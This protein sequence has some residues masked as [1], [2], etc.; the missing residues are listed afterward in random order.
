MHSLDEEYC[1]IL[2]EYYRVK[3]RRK[4]SPHMSWSIIPFARLKKI[5]Q[6]YALNG[7]VR[8]ESGIA[9]IKSEMLRILVRLTAANDLAGHGRY[10]DQ[11]DLNCNYKIPKGDNSDFYFNFLETD[12]GEPVSD[13]GLPKLWAIAQVLMRENN[14]ER[15]LLLCDQILN[16]IHQRGD[17]AALFVEGG[18][19][20]LA[21][22][23]EGHLENNP[24]DPEAVEIW[25]K[26]NR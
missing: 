19:S 21:F 23:H 3:G 6:D 18:T 2:E 20:S 13:Y 14:A 1:N 24:A 15:Q 9:E 8:D 17:L 25:E 12:Y 26:S 22:L 16:I 10:I 11:E 4:K 7:I 5:W